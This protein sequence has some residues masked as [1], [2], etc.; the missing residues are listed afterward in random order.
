MDLI[1][2]ES[3]YDGDYG[4]DEAEDGEGEVGQGG[5]SQ[6]RGLEYGAGVPGDQD[7]GYRR[8]VSDGAAEDLGG[9]AHLAVCVLEHPSGQEDRHILVGEDHVADDAGAD[10]GGDQ[11]ACG[12]DLLEEEFSYCGEHSACGEAAAHSHDADDQPD[13][14][15]HTCHSLGAGELVEHLIP[16]L[17]GGVGGEY[18]EKAVE[19]GPEALVASGDLRCNLGLEEEDDQSA[20]ECGCEEGEPG[21]R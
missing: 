8:G 5:D 7:G 12:V 14:V 6:D 21:R 9:E 16:G 15:D 20:Q 1:V 4:V 18:V 13:G 11:G 19:D 2:G 3:D 10:S 17:D